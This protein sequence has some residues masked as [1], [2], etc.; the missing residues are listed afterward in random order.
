[1]YFKK[2]KNMC[3]YYCCNNTFNSKNAKHMYVPRI[4]EQEKMVVF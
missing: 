4:Y 2:T 1:M 3:K